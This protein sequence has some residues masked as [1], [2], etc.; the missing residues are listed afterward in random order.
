[1]VTDAPHVPGSPPV[2]AGGTG[3]RSDQLEGFRIGVTS[4][5]RSED[6]I[7][8]LE[9]RGA[10]VVHAPTIRIAPAEDDAPLVDDTNAI[11][12]AR[13]DVLLAT[14]SY[15]MR[16]WFE[17]ADASGLGEAL[18]TALADADILVR[19]PKA[20]GSIRAAGLDDAG[21]SDEETTASLVDAV[22]ARP[23]RGLTVAMQLHGFP[24]GAQIERLR[25]E[26][27]TVLTVAPYR[28]VLPEGPERVLRLVDAICKGGMDAVTFTS[29]PPSM[30]SLASPTAR[31][32]SRP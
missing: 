32:D 16:R 13:P 30:P 15:G 24:D 2:P 19:G 8:A 14:T 18:T 22:L 12:T 25:A 11:L 21:M 23:H 6:L 29:A 31:A 3:F 5:R 20:R 28:W 4:D 9:R 10:E 27:V 17:V 7:Q 1:M 26:G